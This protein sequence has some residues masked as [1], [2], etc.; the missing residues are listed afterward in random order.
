MTAMNDWNFDFFALFFGLTSHSMNF[1]AHR[2]F[3]VVTKSTFLVI[4]VF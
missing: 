3:L 2:I 1:K 4:F